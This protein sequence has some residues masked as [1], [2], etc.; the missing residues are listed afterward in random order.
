MRLDLE[1]AVLA[2]AFGIELGWVVYIFVRS[3]RPGVDAVSL[4]NPLVGLAAACVVLLALTFLLMVF[5]R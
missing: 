3:F 5:A 4:T 2:V 1:V